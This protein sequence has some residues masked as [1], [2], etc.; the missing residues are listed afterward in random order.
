MSQISFPETAESDLLELEHIPDASIQNPH[1]QEY[2]KLSQKE[3]TFADLL[4]MNR[5]KTILTNSEQKIKVLNLLYH[6]YESGSKALKAFYVQRDLELFDAHVGESAC[7]I[8]ATKLAVMLQDISEK[9][10]HEACLQVQRYETMARQIAGI[11][12]QYQASL[13]GMDGGLLVC[14]FLKKYNVDCDLKPDHLFLLLSFIL[15]AFKKRMAIDMQTID[16]YLL[17]NLWSI[18]RNSSEIF[19]N[20]IQKIG[21]LLSVDYVLR[22]SASEPLDTKLLLYQLQKDHIG[23]WILPCLETIGLML[24]LMRARQISAL[25]QV[26]IERRDGFK[27]TY[28]YLCK[29]NFFLSI[30]TA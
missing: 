4:S 17:S 1:Y 20:H 22:Q 16:L 10:T 9:D 24:G 30:K 12:Q 3:W 28:Q 27:L 2:L 21:S 5:E 11:I 19:I 18:S 25:V 6:C 26:F 14:D 23:R 7:Q 29:N 8:R 15:S 13:M